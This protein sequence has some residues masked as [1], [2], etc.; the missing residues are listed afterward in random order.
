MK[1]PNY[2]QAYIEEEKL[3]SYL[4]NFDHPDGASKAAFYQAMGFNLSNVEEL[5]TELL[6]LLHDN[7]VHSE[8]ENQ[9]GTKYVVIGMFLGKQER[10]RLLKTI[11]LI[12]KDKEFPRLVTAYPF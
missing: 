11:W 2:E 12:E 7:D 1:V 5:E 3:R 10:T 4:L 8:S 6:R 9:H